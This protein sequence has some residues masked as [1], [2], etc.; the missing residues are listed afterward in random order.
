[1]TLTDKIRALAAREYGMTTNDVPGYTTTQV[2]TACFKLAARGVL[3]R[4]KLA[5]RSVRYFADPGLADALR[6]RVRSGLWGHKGQR[7]GPI[8][9]APWPADAPAVE[10]ERTVYTVCPTFEPRFAEQTLPIYG[11]NQR[12]RV[13]Q[14]QRA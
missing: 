9:S 13:M 14:E 5:H 8:G 2:G 10:T 11:G 12:G 4:V 7:P 1:M 3:H 6:E